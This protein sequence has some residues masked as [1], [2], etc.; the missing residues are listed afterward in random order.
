MRFTRL[1]VSVLATALIVGAMWRLFR[2]SDDLVSSEACNGKEFESTP[3]VAKHDVVIDEMFSAITLNAGEIHEPVLR[4]EITLRNKLGRS[5]R[6]L[7]V[8]KS[9]ACQEIEVERAVIPPGSTC[10]LRMSLEIVTRNPG[11]LRSIREFVKVHTDQG[12]NPYHIGIEGGYIPPVYTLSD[13][14]LL[15]R[16]DE[17]GTIFEG[18][19]CVFVGQSRGV[20]L[21]QVTLEPMPGISARITE[22]SRVPADDGTFTKINCEVKIVRDNKADVDSCVLV[23]HTNSSVAKEAKL[24]LLLPRKKATPLVTAIPSIIGYGVVD[25]T[26]APIQRKITLRSSSRPLRVLSTSAS[27]GCL[28]IES[29]A[30][31]NADVCILLCTLHP[32]QAGTGDC[33]GKLSIVVDIEG[34]QSELVIPVTAFLRDSKQ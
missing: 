19:A 7:K 23:F 3:Y 11:R 12:E 8:G 5:I 4:Q 1:V 13:E 9:C 22:L 31:P 32:R 26:A 17:A 33:D 24:R 16:K 10:A 29:H 21:T 2:P 34:T 15:V 28:T 20:S 18:G 27:H 6:I 25:R 14:T 30:E